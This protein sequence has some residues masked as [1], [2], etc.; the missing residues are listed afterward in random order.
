MQWLLMCSTDAV[1]VNF[2]QVIQSESE[3]DWWY[4]QEIAEENGCEWWCLEKLTEET[5]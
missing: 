2:E 3:P 4:C 1:Y 5:K